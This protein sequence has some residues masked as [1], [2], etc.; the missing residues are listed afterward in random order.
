M[1]NVICEKGTVLPI[2]CWN[3]FAD[4][5][6]ETIDLSNADS[7]KVID[8]EYMFSDCKNLTNL[9]LTGFN[10]SNVTAMSGVFSSC[11]KLAEVDL[12][13]FDTSKAG[14]L[15]GMFSGCKELTTLDVSGFDTSNIKD[16]GF[17]FFGCEKLT[18]LDL[19]GFD[20]ANVT[21][22]NAMFNGCSAL[23]KITASDK[24]STAKVEKSGDMFTKSEKLTGGSG[25]KYNT[26]HLDAEY[27]RIDTAD[28]P[29]YFTAKDTAPQNP[30]AVL[31][32]ATGTL[33]IKG[34]ANADDIKAF[35]ANDK[36]KKIVADEGT[37]LPENS[38]NLF[39][40]SAAESVDLSKAD[41]SN[42]TDMSGMF[43]DMP[44]LKEADLTGCDLSKVTDTSDMFRGDE[45]LETIRVS[46]NISLTEIPESGNMFSGCEKLTGGNGT[47]FDANHTDAEYARPDKDGEPGYFTAKDTAPQNPTA[48]LDEATGTLTIKGNANA[49][50]I[51]AF[52]AND[53]VK[54]IVADEGTI[55]P[56]NSANLFKGSA[57]ESVDLSK[58]DTS[59]VTDMS[60]MF[61]DMPALKEADLTG[62]DLSKV[63]DTS[64]M[65]RG[66]EALE[67]IRVS[68]NI[69][70]TE[71]PE[72]GNMFSG[73]EKLTGGNGTKFDANHTDAEYA[74]PDKDGE[75][76]YFTAK[77]TAPAFRIGDVNE[78]GNVDIMDAMLLTRYTSEWEGIEINLEAAEISGDGDVSLADAMI[79]TRYVNNW[80]GYDHYFTKD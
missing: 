18:E 19:S 43:S 11:E 28:T 60:G 45:A 31:D 54:K 66:D 9:N 16:M 55:L 35:A 57:A 62:C 76:G 70:L 52:A 77:D 29:G 53:K 27:A 49:D 5:E 42:V 63:T 74:R 22:M 37:I 10:T 21:D 39:K 4:F 15:H 64:D 61:S 23:E 78:D 20:T 80:K 68:E 48:V 17:M 7:S 14:S 41:T 25:T 33:T 72:S 50:D 73:C 6:A 44:A 13:G 1:K 38:A 34:N 59:N 56:E 36:V 30:T 79:L 47:K 24:W 32:E 67:T 40:G 12:S 3:L 58:A 2:D 51:K 65:F 8:M 26:A 71:I 46:E 75:P 69:S